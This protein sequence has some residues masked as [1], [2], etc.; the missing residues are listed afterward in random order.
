MTALFGYV[1]TA[2]VSHKMSQ[3]VPQGEFG[4]PL[5]LLLRVVLGLWRRSSQARQLQNGQPVEREEQRRVREHQLDTGAYEEVSQVSL[6]LE[7]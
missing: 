1:R 4:N 6:R 7:A 5:R 3:D 2:L